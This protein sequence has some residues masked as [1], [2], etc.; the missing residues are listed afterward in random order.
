[1]ET[2]DSEY[3]LEYLKAIPLNYTQ[4]HEEIKRLNLNDRSLE[5]ENQDLFIELKYREET[6]QFLTQNIK[7]FIFNSENKFKNQKELNSFLKNKL[8]TTI[9]KLNSYK[10]FKGELMRQNQ[11]LL[12]KNQ[13]LLDVL[14][15]L[16]KKC[17]SYET[18]LC[19][20]H[21]NIEIF[22]RK[23]QINEILNTEKSVFAYITENIEDIRNKFPT[24]FCNC[25]GKF[26]EFKMNFKTLT[27]NH[28]NL[29]EKFA[30]LQESCKSLESNNQSLS[31]DISRLLEEN[32]KLL[33]KCSKTNNPMSIDFE[34]ENIE[35]KSPKITKRRTFSLNIKKK[36]VKD[37][38]PSSH[39]NKIKYAKDKDN[40][41]T[42]DEEKM[43]I[44]SYDNEFKDDSRTLLSE[45]ENS[46]FYKQDTKDLF[47]D[48]G[49][50]EHISNEREQL[51]DKIEKLEIDSPTIPN[52]KKNYFNF[53]EMNSIPLFDHSK[54]N[55]SLIKSKTNIR[56]KKD[57][58]K[59][60]FFIF[61]SMVYLNFWIKVM[62][63]VLRV[64]RII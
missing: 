15:E 2:A 35:K 16:E 30:N 33:Q 55:L 44:M 5:E 22:E 29:L 13:R 10:K 52:S 60:S 28:E 50:S 58:N 27:R 12:E 7:N 17:E 56:I 32:K 8:E 38:T 21:Q 61:I 9:I 25:N 47:N 40:L 3:L 39:F 26:D 48:H 43:K 64:A 62:R 14:D 53:N 42:L 63:K 24:F 18:K 31:N 19:I 34:F 45:L 11:V 41:S 36:K 6:L 37:Y 4:S 54:N 49:Y 1:M 57:F 20:V 46:S 23:K 59:I 51:W